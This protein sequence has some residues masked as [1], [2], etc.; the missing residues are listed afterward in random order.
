M[1][2]IVMMMMMIIVL[3]MMMMMMCMYDDSYCVNYH[4][5]SGFMHTIPIQQLPDRLIPIYLSMKVEFL[6]IELMC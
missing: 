1:M 6:L 5:L 4:D 2:M 3:M